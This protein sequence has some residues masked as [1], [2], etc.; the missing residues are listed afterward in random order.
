MSWCWSRRWWIDGYKRSGFNI[1]EMAAHSSTSDP[2][3]AYLAQ[4]K[5]RIKE[6]KLAPRT[7]DSAYGNSIREKVVRAQQKHSWKS[8]SEDAS[9]FAA[10]LWGKSAT[11]GQIPLAITSICGG[12]ETG[13]LLYSLESGSLCAL[14]EIGQLGEEERRLWNDNRT[15]IRHV[16]VSRENGDMVF[17]ILHENGTANIGVKISGQSGI[18]ELTEGDS[19]D[20]APRWLPG[21]ERKIVFQ[22]AGIGR[23]RQGH[24]LALGP[25]CIQQLDAEAGELTTLL[26]SRQFDYLAP[27]C[28]ED[29]T[30]LFIRRPRSQHERANPLRAI[31]DVV[32]SPFRLLYAVVQYLNFFSAM[33]TG[34]K[35]TSGGA[36]AREMD[37]KQMMVWGNVVR[38]QRQAGVEEEGTDLV[39]KSWQLCSSSP[40]GETKVLAAGVLAYDLSEDGRLVFTNGNAIFLLHPD[41]RKERVLNEAMIEQVFFVRS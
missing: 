41:G 7:V 34:R 38:A 29:G 9:P 25:F 24:Y 10:A 19:F 17:S 3:I 18:Q 39:P 22:S 4:G 12:K 15:Q 40:K 13:A 1:V 14:L 37:M 11:S 32:L 35:L 27:E 23:N 16:S 36:K 31:K 26:E 6:G 20:T 8:A 5:I 2:T 28:L 30:L 21:K 33:Y